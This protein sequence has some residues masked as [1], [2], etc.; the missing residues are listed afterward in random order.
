VKI[1]AVRGHKRAN[2][3]EQARKAAVRRAH[4]KPTEVDELNDFVDKAASSPPRATLLIESRYGP[5][6]VTWSELVDA[7]RYVPGFL[8][9]PQPRPKP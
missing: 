7:A 2:E 8:L 4:R 1:R 3:K 9:P 5:V 6:G